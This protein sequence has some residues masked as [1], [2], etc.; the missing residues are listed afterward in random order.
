M[1]RIFAASLIILNGLCSA[2]FASDMKLAVTTS[3]HNSGL[4][5]ILLPEVK[6]DLDLTVHVL[7]VGTGQALNLARRGDVDAILVHSKK[8]EQRFVQKG[9]SP[10]RREIMYNDFVLVGPSLDPALIGRTGNIGEALTRIKSSGQPFISRGDDSGTHR[11]E[12]SLWKISGF[13]PKKFSKHWYKPVGAGMGAALNT[14]SAMN[15]YILTD[16]GS[17]LNFKN[18]QELKL[19]YWGDEILYNQYSYLPVS[20]EKHPHVKMTEAIELENW[21]TSSKGQKM[22]AEFRIKGE[23]LFVPNAKSSP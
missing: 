2:A 18:K 14:A 11:K 13:T 20:T 15:A 19:L 23:Q 5:A 6:K 3:F 21:L 1:K 10:Y 16:R 12:V 8:A 17:W 9:F 22:I 4:S 7:V